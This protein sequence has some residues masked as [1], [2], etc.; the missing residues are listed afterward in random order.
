MFSVVRDPE[1]LGFPARIV[2][3]LASQYPTKLEVVRN[4]KA[5]LNFLL[6]KQGGEAS[7][8][9]RRSTD[10]IRMCW[11]DTTSWALIWACCCTA[12]GLARST[13]GRGLGVSTGASKE[14]SA[15]AHSPCRWPKAKAESKE[16]SYAE[17]QIVAG[18]LICDTYLSAKDLVKCKNYS[19]H[20]LTETVL[21]LKREEFDFDQVGECLKGADSIARL[22]R[23]CE[24]DAYYQ[25]ML[26]LQLMVL[27]LT[28]Q[29]TCIAGNMWARTLV[30][31]RAERNEY[32]LL[33][34][35]HN[36]KFVCPDKIHGVK[37]TR[38]DAVDYDEDDGGRKSGR[39]K[40]A[41]AGGL[42]LEPKKGLY[43][44]IVLLLDFNSLYPSII[45]EY[46]I[47]FTTV[48]RDYSTPVSHRVLRKCPR[49]LPKGSQTSQTLC[50]SKACCP[51]SSHTS[52]PSAV[53][54]RA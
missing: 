25:A 36:A 7:L 22:L 30:G 54:S 9:Q 37:D 5:L 39:R 44:S 40:P 20:T 10:T 46:N 33:H 31:G 6:G 24:M 11:W 49:R 45:Q 2:E 32:L 18:R 3:Q 48:E 12:C 17:R 13:T 42:V 35:F 52:W 43:D 23:H 4:E 21:K 15:P 1:N 19:L 26:V 50:R 38:A 41:Y 34:E 16:V 29:L 53:W 28:K 27:P 47:C 8:L 51:R 14:A